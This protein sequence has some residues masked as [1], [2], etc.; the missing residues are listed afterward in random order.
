MA[1][2]TTTMNALPRL[3]LSLTLALSGQAVLAHT[4]NC[5]F[6]GKAIASE[7]TVTHCANERMAALLQAGKLEASW[8]AVAPASVKLGPGPK[9]EEWRVVY[10]NPSA[11]DSAK[12]RLF[13]FFTPQGNFVAANHSGQ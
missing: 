13:L 6:H 8:Q 7:A 12:R 5:H 4:G 1:H 9:G 11:S 2:L 3:M 10:D